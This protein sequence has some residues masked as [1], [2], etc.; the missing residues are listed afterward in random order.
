MQKEVAVGIVLY[1]PNIERLRENLNAVF[2]QVEKIFLVDNASANL[3]DIKILLQEFSN[4]D[5][6]VNKE[7]VGVAKALNQLFELA[8]TNGFQWLLTLDDDSVCDENMVPSLFAYIQRENA[9]IV[10]PVAVDDK[11]RSGTRETEV[12]VEEME[13][14]ITA[15]SLTSIKAWKNIGGFDNRM[16]IDF[17]DIEF[18]LRLRLNGYKI[19]RVNDVCVHQ[20]Y[21][22]IVGAFSFLEKEWYL[23]GYSPMRVYYSVRNQ[24]YYMKKHRKK[25]NV[26]KQSL[27]LIGYIG[28]RLVFEKDRIKSFVAICRGIKDGIKM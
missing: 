19:L 22:N 20:Q 1:N 16:F 17:V 12:P 18:C 14:C 2:D 27:Y 8:D 24:I 3:A 5:L 26:R 25:I 23:F 13:D 21:G 9:G 4:C 6:V 28:K 11:M 7:N 10:C 15:G